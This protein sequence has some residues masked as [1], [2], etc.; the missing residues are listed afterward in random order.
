MEWQ[1]GGG[2]SNLKRRQLIR[3]KVPLT[4]SVFK[5]WLHLNAAEEP[6]TVSP[7]YLL[8]W[9]TPQLHKWQSIKFCKQEQ[10][11]GFPAL[12]NLE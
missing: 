3:Q 9:L 10:R 11:S 6:I 5:S 4:R 12:D 7:P 2:V 1:G 8:L